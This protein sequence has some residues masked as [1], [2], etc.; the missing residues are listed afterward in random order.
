MKHL[1]KEN[2]KW[3]RHDYSIDDFMHSAAKH[4]HLEESE[5]IG[6]ILEAL[7]TEKIL[8]YCQ[9]NNSFYLLTN[10]DRVIN[11]SKII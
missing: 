8:N 6:R 7:E 5:L 11:I 9:A 10:E 2:F 1:K 3:Q 4:F